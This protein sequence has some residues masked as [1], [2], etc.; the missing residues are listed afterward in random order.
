MLAKRK[1]AVVKA[2]A[3]QIGVKVNHKQV[4]EVK[5]NHM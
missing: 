5:A 4:Q 3:K 2:K 1:Q